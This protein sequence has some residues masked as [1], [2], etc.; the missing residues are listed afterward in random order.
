[1]NKKEII[2]LIKENYSHLHLKEN[3]IVNARYEYKY[4]GHKHVIVWE[5]HRDNLETECILYL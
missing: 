2:K 4:Y 3:E 1:M 5:L